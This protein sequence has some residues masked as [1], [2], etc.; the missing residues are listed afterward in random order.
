MVFK[1]LDEIG[2]YILLF[3]LEPGTE[4]IMISILLVIV[5]N[6]N[7]LK[8]LPPLT[9]ISQLNNNSIPKERPIIL[10]IHLISLPCH[11]EV[12]LIGHVLA[13]KQFTLSDF[14][15]VGFLVQVLGVDSLGEG[16]DLPGLGLAADVLEPD[17]VEQVGVLGF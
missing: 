11:S 9:L 10:Q 4:S 12:T 15:G 6:R 5:L 16:G 13:L 8:L 2:I 14:L 17:E 7:L 1:K 3:R